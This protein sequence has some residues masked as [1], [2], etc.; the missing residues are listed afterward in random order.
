MYMPCA[1]AWQGP[2]AAGLGAT[3]RGVH[4][5]RVSSRVESRIVKSRPGE[6]A[7]L[8]QVKA[9]RGDRASSSQGLAR[10]PC[11]VKSRPGEEAVL[12]QV[13]AWR[14]DR[15]SHLATTR[16]DETGFGRS[17]PLVGHVDAH[18][19]TCA[20]SCGRLRGLSCLRASHVDP[21]PSCAMGA[22][23]FVW[24]LPLS[25][26]SHTRCALSERGGGGSRW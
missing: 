14:G 15:A 3:A 8:R 7:V 25:H 18:E 2:C 21:G 20:C 24:T 4:P 10:R 6:E 11:F 5:P 1:P 12:R 9:W 16:L 22:G 19:C 26:V 23:S 17:R 13:K